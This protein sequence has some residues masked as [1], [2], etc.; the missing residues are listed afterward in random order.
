MSQWL[1][2]LDFNVT[3]NSVTC[4]WMSNEGLPIKE[5][6]GGR[7][8][9]LCGCGNDDDDG[10]V[11]SQVGCSIN[12]IFNGDFFVQLV[13]QRWRC[14]PTI[15]FISQWS[16]WWLNYH[17]ILLVLKISFPVHRGLL[18]NCLLSWQGYTDPSWE[19]RNLLLTIFDLHINLVSLLFVND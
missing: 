3:T 16:M 10:S 2:D 15:I 5:E 1:H 18:L 12:D 11:L 13:R 9:W 4:K 8:W 19:Q 6:R 17:F 14:T 7:S